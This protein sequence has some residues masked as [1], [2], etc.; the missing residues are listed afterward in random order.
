MLSVE[1]KPPAFNNLMSKE[2][3]HMYI[4]VQVTLAKYKENQT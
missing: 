2:A 4:F 1:K 3:L